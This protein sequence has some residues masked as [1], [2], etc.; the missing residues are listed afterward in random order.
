M[1]GR[2][3]MSLYQLLIILV[4]VSCPFSA[5]ATTAGSSPATLFEQANRDYSQGNYAK[6]ASLYEEIATTHGLSAHLLYNLG[7]SYS[8]NSQ[9]GLAVLSYLQALRITPGDSDI[10]GNLQLLRKEQGLF[11]PD[12][13]RSQ[14]FTHLLE[15]D[16]WCLAAGIAFGLLTLLHLLSFFVQIGYKTKLYLSTLLVLI[17]LIFSFSIYNRYQDYHDGVVTAGDVHLRISPFQ[18]ASSIGN[19]MEGR[20]IRPVRRHGDY[21]LVEDGSG[22]S[23]WLHQGDFETISER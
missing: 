9:P 20:V 15:M 1:N 16:Q 19:L 14:Q 11:Q 23:G 5:T 13:T 4:L 17:I 8:R 21:Y 22:R 3:K 12:Q 10:K 7:N 6:A 2:H 18:A